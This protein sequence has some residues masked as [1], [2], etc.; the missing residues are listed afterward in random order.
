M[1]ERKKARKVYNIIYASSVYNRDARTLEKLM[2]EILGVN[3][4]L[5]KKKKRVNDNL[6]FFHSQNRFFLFLVINR[7]NL[8]GQNDAITVCTCLQHNNR[9]KKLNLKLAGEYT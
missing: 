2:R 5:A 6:Y 8:R 3:L 1:Y 7:T 4:K 9:Y